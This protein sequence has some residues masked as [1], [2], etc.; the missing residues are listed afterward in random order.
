MEID[1]DKVRLYRGIITEITEL[2]VSIDLTGRMGM[3]RFPLR[4]L[5]S[6]KKP[7]VG[8]EIAIYLGYPEVI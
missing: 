6:D 1:T 3:M 5:I 4:M 2:S 7:E 8:A